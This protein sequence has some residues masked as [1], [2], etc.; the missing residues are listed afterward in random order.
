MLRHKLRVGAVRG[1]CAS[2]AHGHH[3][4]VLVWLMSW[5]SSAAISINV[6]VLGCCK[7]EFCYMVYNQC[8]LFICLDLIIKNREVHI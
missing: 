3:M 6:F 1:A 4:P 7:N 2:M 8:E 5:L